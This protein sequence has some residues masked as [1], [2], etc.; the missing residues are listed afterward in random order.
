MSFHTNT[1]KCIVFLGSSVTSLEVQKVNWGCYSMHT[2]L[3]CFMLLYTLNILLTTIMW[4]LTAESDLLPAATNEL[5]KSVSI[6]I[7]GS[8]TMLILWTSSTRILWGTV[9]R[10]IHIS[11]SIWNWNEPW[12]KN[13]SWW[14]LKKV[15]GLVLP[16]LWWTVLQSSLINVYFGLCLRC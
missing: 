2:Q 13:K 4:W 14:I 16:D 7:N 3:Y 10:A 8:Y 11:R 6:Y 5:S 9:W 12:N 15:G 1:V